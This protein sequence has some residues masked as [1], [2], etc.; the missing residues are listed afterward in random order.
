MQAKITHNALEKSSNIVTIIKNS[1]PKITETSKQT[2]SDN[3]F[4]LKGTGKELTKLTI[5]M[6]ENSLT[7]RDKNLR[8]MNNSL[9]EIVIGQINT[10]KDGN[11]E[12]DIPISSP[13]QYSFKV[14]EN[15]GT[16]SELTS[17]NYNYDISLEQNKVTLSCAPNPYNPTQGTLKAEYILPQSG[18]V[19]IGIYSISGFKVYGTSI[20]ENAIGAMKGRNILVWDGKVNGKTVIPGLYI[21]VLKVSGKETV[22][23]TKRVGIKW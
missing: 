8:P 6:I 23:K 7:I 5:T 9:T 14:Y 20:K 15:Y 3:T 21:V 19:D 18:N 17:Q 12:I 11:W 4:K 13:G 1:Q 16:A 2:I 22:I 10:D